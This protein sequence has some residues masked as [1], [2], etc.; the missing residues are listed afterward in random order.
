MTKV[1]PDQFGRINPEK[2]R[3]RIT[4]ETILVS[5]GWASNEIG[6]VQP[7]PAIAEML[8]GRASALH[9]DARRGARASS[10]STWPPCRSGC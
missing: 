9:V 10:P 2:L 1:P 6:T 4:D 3:T 7:I 5:V 8:A